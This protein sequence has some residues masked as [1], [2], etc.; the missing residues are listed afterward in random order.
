MFRLFKKKSEIEKLE[1]QYKKKMKEGYDLQSIDRSGS[2]QKY[3]EADLILKKIQ[4]IE[5][6]DKIKS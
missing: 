6:N 1:D 5:N 3:V 2:D 4:S